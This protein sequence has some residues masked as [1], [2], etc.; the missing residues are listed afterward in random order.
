MTKVR[1]D[2][3]TEIEVSLCMMQDLM[4]E[5]LCDMADEKID[6]VI[7]NK[8]YEIIGFDPFSVVLKVTGY[9]RED[10]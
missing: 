6:S 9:V 7:F 4:G 1:R 3:E 10:E 2:I 8:G 5:S